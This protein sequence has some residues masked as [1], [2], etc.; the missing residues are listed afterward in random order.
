[1]SER[2]TVT[3]AVL[4]FRRN[5]ELRE[6]LPLILQQLQDQPADGE[7]TD[8]L[9]VDND[10]AAAA[11]PTV[12]ALGDSRVRYACEPAPGIA[13]ARNRALDECADRDIL[14]FIDDDERPT[15]RWLRGLLDTRA[16]FAVDAVAGPV[17]SE[18]Y[19]PVDP[20]IEAGA[21]FGRRHR[22]HVTTGTAI[23]VAATNNLL[24]DLRAVRRLG[25]RFPLDVGMAGGEDNLFTRTLV[26]RGARMVW[27]SEAL[28]TEAVPAERATR[29]WVLLRSLS[30]GNVLARVLLR[31]GPAGPAAI[32]LRASLLFGG[33]ARIFGGAARCLIGY[34]TGSLTHRARG[35]RTAIRGVGIVLG[36]S[37]YSYQAYKRPDQ[38]LVETDAKRST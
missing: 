5:D 19:G 13:A 8:V 30:S 16:E 23:S 35:L 34:V 15:E 24:L 28:V 29:R 22:T 21:F 6:L 36:A 26:R 7:V 32:R 27:C 38:R 14:V 25:V 33:A 1:M 31:T 37:G 20:W 11:R 10:P 3:V 9:V 2:L 12:D 4:T 17:R 18:F